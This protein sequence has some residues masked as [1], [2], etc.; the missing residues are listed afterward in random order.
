MLAAELNRSADFTA[1]LNNNAGFQLIHNHNA[2]NDRHQVYSWVKQVCSKKTN[3]DGFSWHY[4]VA[5]LVCC[6]IAARAL[7]F[8]GYKTEFP[9]DRH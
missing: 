3:T 4:Q 8:R 5:G 2:E 9:V 1:E 6:S 7:D